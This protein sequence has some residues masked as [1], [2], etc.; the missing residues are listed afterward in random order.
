MHYVL[1]A[2]RPLGSFLPGTGKLY[3]LNPAPTAENEDPALPR[4]AICFMQPSS[5]CIIVPSLHRM[6]FY[7][8][9][10]WD[11][12]CT[13][14]GKIT[15]RTYISHKKCSSSTINMPKKLPGMPNN[16]LLSLHEKSRFFFSWVC[17]AQLTP[18]WLGRLEAAVLWHVV[19]QAFLRWGAQCSGN[20]LP[21]FS[22][23]QT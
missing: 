9:P 19:A 4:V 12:T 21:V 18:G 14:Q 6:A 16:H 23:L 11:I 22:A 10:S 13:V 3:S 15:N 20:Q 2:A 1:L 8:H 17:S 5:S 7:C